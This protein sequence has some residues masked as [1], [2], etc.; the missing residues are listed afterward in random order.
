ML[1]YASQWVLTA[2]LVLVYLTQ[3]TT[4]TTVSLLDLLP[5]CA[6]QCLEDFISTEYPRGACSEGCDL[7]YLCKT[8]TTS[9][10]TLGEA[11]L[12]CSLS[13]CS[14]EVALSFDTY[15]ICDNVPGALPRTH[16]T[17]FA[18][19]TS[20]AN[21]TSTAGPT[22]V[23]ATEPETTDTPT[24][25]RPLS[26]E[27]ANTST[28]LTT[29]QSQASSPESTEHPKTE[30][31]KPTATTTGSSPS[32]TSSEASNEPGQGSNLNSGA[33]IGVSVASGIAGFF[34]IGVII[35]FCCRKIRRKA[36]DREFFEIGGHMT[37]PPDFC[38]PPKRPPMGPRPSP[39]KLF[40][41]DSESV[42]LVSPADAEYHDPAQ[43]P[44]VVVTQ[45]EEDYEYGRM[46]AK[47]TDR[48]GFQ[49]TSNLDFDAESTVSS[50]T[51]SDLLPDKPTY[52]LYPRPLRW[53]QQ[54][55]VKPSSEAT[56]FEEN[57]AR[58]ARPRRLPSP[59]LQQ[60][61]LAPG[62]ARG[63][64]RH[65]MA[66]LPANPRAMMYGFG[67]PGLTPP[68]K[69]SKHEKRPVYSS[70][71]EQAQSSRQAAVHGTS[72]HPS[73][74]SRV[75]YDDDLDNYWKNSNAG[76][77]GAKVIQ[78]QHQPQSQDHS[79]ARGA[80]ANRNSVS[81]YPGY[82]FEFGFGDSSSSSEFRR[83]SRHSGG[84]RP[85]TPVREIRTPLREMQNPMGESLNHGKSST[86]RY[87]S[88]T[89]SSG[90]GLHPLPAPPNP[91]HPQEIISR[92]RIVR[93]DDIKRVQIRRGKPLPS[94]KDSEITVPYSPDDFW[95]EPKDAPSSG[96]AYILPAPRSSANYKKYT[97]KGQLGMPKKKP[98]PPERNLT[99][100]RRGE[101]LILQVE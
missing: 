64:N 91:L 88:T 100:S 35:F 51:V 81:D 85:L 49:S 98:L 5:K 93:Q 82:Q 4:T 69:G 17:I 31:D 59:P 1:P 23:I 44:A 71:N 76:F 22:T 58:P 70:A 54:K 2:A 13:K 67:G 84:F 46:S 16:P 57:H 43:Y 87:L 96:S 24:T 38:F 10:Y 28:S 11:G 48:A 37:E 32:A 15:S 21:P 97:S 26:T 78:P 56:V 29:S 52:E 20:P 63:Q 77:V 68:W 27:T 90:P 30:T 45:P 94:P 89:K 55:K 53:S 65:L 72:P 86:A 95:F 92:P 34:I 83:A 7:N 66:G 61:G 60:S 62:N 39:K 33:V 73:G 42:R 50:R 8:E 18:T 74:H 19:I 75:D 40:G 6:S 36:Q 79:T 41:T 47:N 12:R 25:T 9:G 3:G 101:D 99:P 14:M 80:G